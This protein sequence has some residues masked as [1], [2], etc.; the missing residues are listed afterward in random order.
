[1][2]ANDVGSRVQAIIADALY[3]DVGKVEPSANLMRDLGAESIDFLDIVFRLEKSFGIK[4]PKGDAEKKAR[5]GLIEDQFAIGGALTGKGATQLR[6]AMP[7]IAEDEIKE[8]FQIR[9]IPSLFTVQTFV[10]MVKEQL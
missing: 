7:E 9:S 6:A 2:E 10:R 5:G 8:G 3:V 4:I 1:M